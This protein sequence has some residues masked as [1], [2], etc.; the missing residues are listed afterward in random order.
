MN[1]AF[2]TRFALELF[3]AHG[4]GANAMTTLICFLQ[5]LTRLDEPCPVP[6][7]VLRDIGLSRLIVAFR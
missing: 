3:T 6:D 7:A 2:S 1:A 4:L 5:R